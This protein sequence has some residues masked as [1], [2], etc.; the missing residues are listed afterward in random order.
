MNAEAFIISNFHIDKTHTAKTPI[1]F[2]PSCES[3]EA[4]VAFLVHAYNFEGK[5][6]GNEQ[7]QISC[8]IKK[9]SLAGRENRTAVIILPSLK[10]L[11]KAFC[12]NVRFPMLSHAS[13]KL[14]SHI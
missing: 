1:L 3:L 13:E 9:P 10:S 7:E 6:E 12:Q 14:E 2:F 4:S 11:I 5:R 8:Q